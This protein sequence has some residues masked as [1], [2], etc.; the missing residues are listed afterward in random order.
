MI[1][2]IQ[3]SSSSLEP[4]KA[5][6]HIKELQ[7][8]HRE[9]KQRHLTELNKDRINVKA[10]YQEI[11]HLINDLNKSG[12]HI[13]SPEKLMRINVEISDEQD[14]QIT[15]MSIMR[16][17]K[18][19]IFECKA[20]RV[21]RQP[22]A[23]VLSQSRKSNSKGRSASERSRSPHMDFGS[24]KQDSHQTRRGQQSMR[25]FSYRLS[26]AGRE[27]SVNKSKLVGSM[28]Y[29][30]MRDDEEEMTYFSNSSGAEALRFASRNHLHFQQRKHLGVDR[31]GG[32]AS[33]MTQTQSSRGRSSPDPLSSGVTA[34]KATGSYG[35]S[36]EETSETEVIRMTNSSGVYTEEPTGFSE[37]NSGFGMVFKP[38]VD[39]AYHENL[40]STLEKRSPRYGAQVEVQA[41]PTGSIVLGT[42]SAVNEMAVD[43]PNTAIGGATASAITASVPNDSSHLGYQQ[44]HDL[45][46]TTEG[47]EPAKYPRGSQ[48]HPNSTKRSSSKRSTLGQDPPKNSPALTEMAK[49]G[50]NNQQR[51]S[52]KTIVNHNH[53]NQTIMKSKQQ[54]FSFYKLESM[55]SNFLN[56]SEGTGIEEVP[57][58]SGVSRGPNQSPQNRPSRKFYGL[59]KKRSPTKH[60][61]NEMHE[62]V[63]ESQKSPRNSLF[64]CGQQQTRFSSGSEF[65][66]GYYAPQSTQ[67]EERVQTNLKTLIKQKNKRSS[68]MTNNTSNEHNSE[69]LQLQYGDGG[70]REFYIGQDEAPTLITETFQDYDVILITEQSRGSQGGALATQNS[71]TGSEVMNVVATR[72]FSSRGARSR[73]SSKEPQY[74]VERGPRDL[75]GSQRSPTNSRVNLNPQSSYRQKEN[76]EPAKLP[77]EK[78]RLVKLTRTSS[79]RVFELVEVTD[80]IKLSQ[81]ASKTSHRHGA[82]SEHRSCSA[83]SNQAYSHSKNHHY[84]QSPNPARPPKTRDSVGSTRRRI[85]N[86]TTRRAQAQERIIRQEGTSPTFENRSVRASRSKSAVKTHQKKSTRERPASATKSQNRDSQ[87][88]AANSSNSGGR[89]GGPQGDISSTTRFNSSVKHDSVAGNAVSYQ[90]PKPRQQPQ[91][92]GSHSGRYSSGGPRGRSRPS[93]QRSPLDYQP[94]FNTDDSSR[95][96][97]NVNAEN[98][99]LISEK[100]VVREGIVIQDGFS[101]N[102]KSRRNHRKNGNQGQNQ[103]QQGIV[104]QSADR[105]WSGSK[106]KKRVVPKLHQLATGAQSRDTKAETKHTK[107]SNHKN[108]S[109][110]LGRRRKPSRRRF[111]SEDTQKSQIPPLQLGE[112]S[113]PHPSGRGL[114]SHDDHHNKDISDFK[115]SGLQSYQSRSSSLDSR[116]ISLNIQLDSK[117]LLR[118][119]PLM[120]IDSALAAAAKNNHFLRK[121]QKKLAKLER[122]IDEGYETEGVMAGIYTAGM[123]QMAAPGHLQ[124]RL[125][126]K[127]KLNLENVRGGHSSQEV[128]SN[129]KHI[130]ETTKELEQRYR[131]DDKSFEKKFDKILTRALLLLS[132]LGN[133]I[134]TL[135]QTK[136]AGGDSSERSGVAELRVLLNCTQEFEN[137]VEKTRSLLK[138]VKMFEG[139]PKIN[140]VDAIYKNTVQVMEQFL[141]SF[142]LNIATSRVKEV[143]QKQRSD[144]NRH[145]QAKE[146]YASQDNG[147]NQI[148]EQFE[149]N[150]Q[151]IEKTTQSR[152][153]CDKDVIEGAKSILKELNMNE[154]NLYHQLLKTSRRNLR[155][156]SEKKLNPPLEQ[157]SEEQKIV[158]Q[159]DKDLEL[160][161]HEFLQLTH[162]SELER[163]ER[164]ELQRLQIILAQKQEEIRLKIVEKEHLQSRSHRGHQNS[165]KEPSYRAEVASLSSNHN[166]PRTSKRVQIGVYG[167]NSDSNKGKKQAKEMIIDTDH[168]GREAAKQTISDCLAKGP[169]IVSKTTEFLN[170]HTTFFARDTAKPQSRKDIFTQTTGENNKLPSSSSSERR[171]R[172][173]DERSGSNNRKNLKNSKILSK[174]IN[175][176]ICFPSGLR[177]YK[178]KVKQGEGLPTTLKFVSPT[179]CAIGFDSGDFYFFDLNKKRSL[180]LVRQKKHRL[181]YEGPITCMELFQQFKDEIESPETSVDSRG[182]ILSKEG[183][184][185]TI[186]RLQTKLDAPK[187]S[188]TAPHRKEYLVL[189]AGLNEP[190][191]IKWDI[192]EMIITQIIDMGDSETISC[193]RDL[194][195]GATVVTSCH[196]GLLKFWDIRMKPAFLVQEINDFE[197]PIVSLD[198][199]PADHTLLVAEI[200]GRVTKFILCFEEDIYHGCYKELRVDLGTR[201]LEMS[202]IQPIESEGDGILVLDQN[203]QLSIFGL[204]KGKERQLMSAEHEILDFLVV[205]RAGQ[206]PL[207]VL[208]LKNYRIRKIE[209]WANPEQAE[210][211]KEIS[212]EEMPVYRPF[213]QVIVEDG[214]LMLVTCEE[215]QKRL[216]LQQLL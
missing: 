133:N 14:L 170:S 123:T 54:S 63:T 17:L 24:P 158:L 76:R 124:K 64:L 137:R 167:L 201:I 168:T 147:E 140:F 157:P 194:G 203:Q 119:I 212:L 195:D 15:L 71:E 180:L 108:T 206:G 93:R 101:Q 97:V 86:T 96:Y 179:V 20:H 173:R 65:R 159:K 110:N 209:D 80:P 132:V 172:Q 6:S 73:N 187:H 114:D 162:N 25:E 72:T 113:W 11:M 198:Y 118:D 46:L 84:V 149:K 22:K 200:G 160:H 102:H 32:E 202:R 129:L 67:R 171:R 134:G 164:T 205:D 41:C 21:S 85:P 42:I 184:K 135:E 56:S 74:Q 82:T 40:L 130:L 196:N 117:Q 48:N 62:P 70:A 88:A 87:L 109:S 100:V 107:N 38:A 59:T 185:T 105:C 175:Q 92:R 43:P 148:F 81:V 115:D 181:A 26:R 183:I 144:T 165:L 136:R 12:I 199:S 91:G 103:N 66:E 99:A 4:A 57:S 122:A 3:E 138:E 33:S 2:E 95:N 120:G 53:K 177:R 191:L 28:N 111:E 50:P 207:L 215:G 213:S 190:C 68:N 153:L 13:K 116:I 186:N 176:K 78:Q 7:T 139:A 31:H 112:R 98:D 19:L 45:P 61:A 131:K 127:I 154:S 125:M 39:S 69:R 44:Q 146:I 141:E 60:T 142:V 29:S 106:R 52:N 75:H 104:Y 49:T 145:G 89:R 18:T 182:L 192:D 36:V 150:H 163:R 55:K 27:R 51:I 128:V 10:I 8:N 211:V 30:T 178:L 35:S 9:M 83:H 152:I 1:K 174:K 90:S 47:R 34:T 151:K 188:K 161:K 23:Q 214:R 16:N 216:I 210:E 204:G 169:T 5:K 189:A 166:L 193:I 79:G 155:Q 208:V 126:K 77:P 121:K 94:I 37:E 197:C 156:L 143:S 58:T